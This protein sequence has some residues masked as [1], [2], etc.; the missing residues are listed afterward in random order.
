MTMSPQRIADLPPIP[1]L[2]GMTPIALLPVRLET[3]YVAGS[4]GTP[5]LRVRVYPDDL[6]IDAHE[7]ELTDLER[8]WAAHYTGAVGA[9]SDDEKLAAWAQLCDHFGAA[10][11][12][13]I[14]QCTR[15]D[16]TDPGSRDSMW[17]RAAQTSVLPHQWVVLGYRDGERVIAQ[18]GAEIPRPLAVGPTPATE[19]SPTASIDSMNWLV[20]FDAAVANGMALEIPMPKPF[21]HG[22]DLLLVLGVQDEA[23]GAERLDGLLAAHHY[24]DG[25]AVLPPELPT[26]NTADAASGFTTDDP[27][28]IRSFRRELGPDLCAAGDGSDSARLAAALGL[29]ATVFAH[30]E[31]ADQRRNANSQAMHT[32]LWSAT[33]GYLFDTML[34]GAVLDSVHEAVR[35]HFVDWVRAEGPLPALR[36]GRQPYGVLPVLPITGAVDP[37]VSVPL[38]QLA[39]TLANLLPLWTAA[40]DASGPEGPTVTDLLS[41]TPV[42]RAFRARGSFIVGDSDWIDLAD[43]FMGVPVD[44]LHSRLA[45]LQTELER[46]QQQITPWTPQLAGR[47]DTL[48]FPDPHS[49]GAAPDTS[50]AD[51]PWHVAGLTGTLPLVQPDPPAG[52]EPAGYLG[53]LSS[54]SLDD[55]VAERRH[56]EHDSLLYLLARHATGTALTRAGAPALPPPPAAPPVRGSLGDRPDDNGPNGLTEMAAALATLRA[57]PVADLEGLMGGALDLSAGRL[58]AWVTS[59]ATRRLAEVRRDGDRHA[60]V[61]GCYGMVVDLPEPPVEPPAPGSVLGSADTASF[62]HAPSLSHATTAAVLRSGHLPPQ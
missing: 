22:L 60:L 46:L 62:I 4:D 1:A 45:A 32:L 50:T 37:N 54:A 13:W 28:H 27:G 16:H 11:A 39:E 34:S 43:S 59:L 7:P 2:A 35:R 48:T 33:W 9:A 61:L 56:P 24:T 36:I 31:S 6:A 29:D 26:N 5:V 40:G 47:T 15:A 14:V 42:C 55:I 3:R 44:D 10:R 8:E 18:A 58:D 19:D 57:L 25:I 21:A 17:T 53:D 38:P 12:A 23:A 20:D 51:G 30:V 49:D 41:Q 52:S